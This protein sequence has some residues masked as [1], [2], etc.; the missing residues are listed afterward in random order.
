LRRFQEVDYLGICKHPLTCA[1][2]VAHSSWSCP[3][4]RLFQPGLV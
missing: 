4:K 3:Q 1:G 2:Q